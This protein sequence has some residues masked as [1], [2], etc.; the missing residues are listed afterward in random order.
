MKKE[1]T[2]EQVSSA[3]LHA[4]DVSS[5]ND[6]VFK[7]E[8]ATLRQ[9]VVEQK[10]DATIVFAVRRP[11]CVLC[12]EHGKQL[13]NLSS[14]QIAVLGVVK[15]IGVDDAG[16]QEFHRNYFNSWPIYLDEEMQLYKAMGNRSILKVKTLFQMI[17]GMRKLSRR[18]S[19][20]GIGGNMVGEGTIQG[21][22]LIFDAKG[23]LVH[24][25]PETIMNE[26][27]MI[28]IAQ[29]LETIVG[30]EDPG[31]K[32]LPAEAPRHCFKKGQVCPECL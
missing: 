32:P 5:S 23:D 26:I 20:K 15:E 4:L 16:L 3:V 24:V 17:T 12:R 14:T 6:A 19:Q 25:Q 8:S 21:G 10:K 7:T 22:I 18:M 13:S 29:V 28:E 30:E 31:F 1:I 9:I 11:G 27:N 2:S